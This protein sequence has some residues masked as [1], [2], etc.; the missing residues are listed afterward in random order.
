[1]KVQEII[2]RHGIEEILHFT[3]NKGLTGILATGTVKARNLLPKEKYLEYIYEYNCPNRS[4]DKE[5]WGYA[6]LSITSVNR[7]LFNISSG[8]WHV[9]EDGWWCVLSFL[10]E[11]C[12][13][14]GVYFTTTNNMYSGVERRQEA[15]GLEALF[16]PRICQWTSNYI[17][18]PLDCPS[19]QPTCHQAEVLYPHEV[20][21]KYCTRI[22]VGN[23]ENAAKCESIQAV[24]SD[25]QNI[26][27]DVRHDLF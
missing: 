19:N 6:N 23:N 2:D 16:A 4:R 26:P 10:P 11:I 13:H 17:S 5:W 3:T 8:K 14:K 27:C 1:M 15:E 21:L 12:T 25:Y 20:S 7:K 9:D 22:Y 18:R 24:F